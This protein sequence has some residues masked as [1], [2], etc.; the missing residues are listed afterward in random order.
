MNTR[1]R[2]CGRSA[3]LTGEFGDPGLEIAVAFEVG[4]AEERR[5]I[6][7]ILTHEAAST[8]RL[9]ALAIAT[10]TDLEVADAIDLLAKMPAEAGHGCAGFGRLFARGGR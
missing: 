3:A 9:T 5:R 1:E 4:R 2:I 7:D 6:G 8:R 10:E